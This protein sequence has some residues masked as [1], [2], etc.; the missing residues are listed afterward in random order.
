MSN[1]Q[2]PWRK[3]RVGS[4]RRH[5]FVLWP[6]SKEMK[7]LHCSH[8]PVLVIPWDTL[9]PAY[10]DPL[11]VQAPRLPCHVLMEAENL[12]LQLRS[13]LS[14]CPTQSLSCTSNH[15]LRPLPVSPVLGPRLAGYPMPFCIPSTLPQDTSP[16]QPQG[17]SSSCQE[18]SL[19]H[20]P[21]SYA[22]TTPTTNISN[23]GALTK[24]WELRWL[25]TASAA[26]YPK[27]LRQWSQS[28]AQ[29]MKRREGK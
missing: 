2:T 23:V 15:L 29:G 11:E 9:V 24:D 28:L 3:L 25:Q 19:R 20:S 16:P 14:M 18:T 27:S 4:D 13:S 26:M 17:I 5:H 6:K 8:Q 1:V 22:S 7:V 21:L 12:P 10:L